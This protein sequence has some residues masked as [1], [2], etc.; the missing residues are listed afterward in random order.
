MSHQLE[1]ITKYTYDTVGKIYNLVQNN[2]EG[3]G[4]V[5]KHVDQISDFSRRDLAHTLETTANILRRYQRKLL[6]MP[7]PES[8]DPI[9]KVVE[10]AK[11]N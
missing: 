1:F 8:S 2:V 10:L 5:M 4:E 11:R 7:Q 3:L 6:D 9:S